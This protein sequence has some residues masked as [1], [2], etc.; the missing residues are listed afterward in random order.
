MKTLLLLP[1]ILIPSA[2]LSAST[3]IEESFSTTAPGSNLPAGWVPTNPE[4]VD[5]ASLA[6]IPYQ[7]IH[8]SGATGGSS[9]V[10][11]NGTQGDIID[12]YFQD[13][14]AS[15]V[16]RYGGSTAQN[17]SLRG[18]VFRTQSQN[19]SAPG[20]EEFWGYSAG[21]IA[22]GTGRGLYLY[23]NPTGTG[24][25][26]HGTALAS[27]AFDAD[28][29]LN[30]QYTLK[31]SAIGNDVAVSLWTLDESEEIGSLTYASAVTTGGYFGLRAAHA[32][33]N[34]TTSY[35][36]L[37][38]TVHSIPEPHTLGFL[39]VGALAALGVSRRISK[40]NI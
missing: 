7:R 6:G 29:G 5:H 3:L 9:A 23:E 17:Q 8:R 24:S 2:A 38:I 32:N 22:T 19:L 12:G 25:G 30:I 33:S 26:D 10:Y 40:T 13:F 28:L 37:S 36:D 31:I 16:I 20:N 39:A 27:F 11:Y 14:D 34:A 15:L 21:F 1:I 4:A 35:R 18:I